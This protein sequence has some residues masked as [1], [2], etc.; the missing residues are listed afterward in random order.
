MTGTVD[1]P[2]KSDFIPAVDY[3]LIVSSGAADL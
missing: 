2:F 3:F 1:L